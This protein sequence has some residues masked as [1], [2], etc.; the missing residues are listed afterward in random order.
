MPIAPP[1]HLKEW[2]NNNRHKLKPPVG[3]QQLYHENSDF[4]VMVVGGPN[5]RKDFHVNTGEELFYQ[6]EGDITLK[7]RE[8]GPDGMEKT[9]D[10]AIQEG[11]LFLLPGGIPHSP[12]RPAQ[13]VGLVIE[14][15]RSA[16]EKDGFKWFCE[17]CDAMLYEVYLPVSDIVGQ[18]P[19]VMD[20][21]FGNE[22]LCTCSHC[23]TKMERPQLNQND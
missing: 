9:R 19:G 22:L 23:G 6:L 10:I 7:I 15:Y 3:N 17:K 11:D 13:T 14:R 1:F 12:Q 2:I 18:L 16:S 21:F 20:Q 4:I 5:A 8:K